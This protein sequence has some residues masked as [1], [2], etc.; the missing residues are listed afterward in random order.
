MIW[1]GQRCIGDQLPRQRGRALEAADGDLSPISRNATQNCSQSD[2]TLCAVA[3][4]SRG[5]ICFTL[6]SDEHDV[7][8]SR[9]SRQPCLESVAVDMLNFPVAE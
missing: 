2:S 1:A 8:R 7:F 4:L 3:I 9:H 6:P 5:M